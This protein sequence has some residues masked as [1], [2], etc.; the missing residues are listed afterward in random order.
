[1]ATSRDCD[2]MLSDHQLRNSLS[3]QDLQVRLVD[4]ADAR[5]NRGNVGAGGLGGVGC[6]GEALVELVVGLDRHAELS[7]GL[8]EERRRL[9]PELVLAGH[10]E[11]FA[12]PRHPVDGA[13]GQGAER[14][15]DHRTRTADAIAGDDAGAGLVL[16]ESLD[17]DGA[18]REHDARAGIPVDESGPPLAGGPRD[19]FLGD[20]A[21]SFEAR[22]HEPS[23]RG[24]RLDAVQDQRGDAVGA[25]RHVAEA[26]ELLRVHGLP[27]RF[28]GRKGHHGAAQVLR[29]RR[30]RER[31]ERGGVIGLGRL[32]DRRQ[33]GGEGEQGGGKGV[34]HR[35]EDRPDPPEVPVTVP[36]LA[37]ISFHAVTRTASRHINSTPTAMASSLKSKSG[38]WSGGKG[39]PPGARPSAQ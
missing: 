39:A 1:M 27:H 20:G 32:R 9:L 31:R 26:D 3:W 29:Q 34:A 30:R 11:C 10:M 28:V 6:R 37:R 15:R 18:A 8:R 19:L 2:G 25:E 7:A 23:V 36:G 21:V 4:G 16:H 13:V 35:K 12:G 22:G 14:V 17:A 33:G 24:E 38:A 5:E